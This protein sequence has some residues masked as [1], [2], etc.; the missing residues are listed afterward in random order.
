MVTTKKLFLFADY[1]IHSCLP[2]VARDACM[3]VAFLSPEFSF[4]EHNFLKVSSCGYKVRS[5]CGVRPR[6]LKRR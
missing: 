5:D 1:G 3:Q 2:A 6:H 4:P